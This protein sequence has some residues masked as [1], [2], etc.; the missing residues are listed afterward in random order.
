M[1]GF[2]IE[3][4]NNLLEPK[5]VEAMGTAIWLYMWFL[6]KI[7]SISE[8]GVGKTVGGRPIKFEEVEEELGIS[9][10][11]YRRWIAA[12][13][14]EGY[15]NVTVA[16]Y[17]LIVSVNKA[18]KRFGNRLTKNGTPLEERYA[19]NGTPP[20]P[21]TAHLS[22]KN[23]TPNKTEQYTEQNTN[24]PPVPKAPDDEIAKFIHLFKEINPMI[25]KLYGRMPQ[26][27]AAVRLLKLHPLEW[28]EKFMV[29][30]AIRLED[31]FCPKAT[32]PIQLEEKL[33]AIMAYAKS[34]KGG[35]NV[36]TV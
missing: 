33:G 29:A 20:V 10:R 5:H 31:R 21:Q 36:A 26:R 25:G 6:D 27:D 17:G 8:E 24:R 28:W 14:K 18:Y 35:S 4:K 11:T 3:I 13:K 19:T 34:L 12:L 15:I 7:T 9:M 32:T 23:G 16:P 22:T 2:G 30:Y 1:K